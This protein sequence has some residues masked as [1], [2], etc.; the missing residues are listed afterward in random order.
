MSVKTNMLEKG[1][2]SDS[3]QFISTRWGKSLSRYLLRASDILKNI[4]GVHCNVP[5]V[6]LSQPLRTPRSDKDRLQ[7]VRVGKVNG[8][9][10]TTHATHVK[11]MREIIHMDKIEDMT[12]TNP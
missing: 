3:S 9:S 7:A 10:N 8:L 2:R 4:T 11:G 5:Y 12:L 1:G 6:P